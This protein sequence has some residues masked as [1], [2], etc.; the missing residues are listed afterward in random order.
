MNLEKLGAASSEGTLV[1]KQ[2]LA[3][4]SMRVKP[5]SVKRELISGKRVDV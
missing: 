5:A 1:E 4:R 2:A 3:R